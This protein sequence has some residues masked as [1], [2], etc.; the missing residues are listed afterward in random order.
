MLLPGYVA[1]AEALPAF[2]STTTLLAS[3]DTFTLMLELPAAA[4]ASATLLPA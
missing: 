1:F 4:G 2:T 3:P